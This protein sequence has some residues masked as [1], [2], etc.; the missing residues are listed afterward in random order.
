[1]RLNVFTVADTNYEPF[2]LPYIVS[3]LAHNSDAHVELVLDA[4]LRFTASN[5][6][7]LSIIRDE[8]GERFSFQRNTLS[9]MPANSHRFMLEPKVKSEYVY[10][11]DIDIL[12]LEAITESHLKHMAKTGLP[13]SN[14]IRPNRKALTG[15]HFTRYDAYYPIASIPEGSIQGMDEMLLY[16]I[17]EARGYGLPS[18][19]DVFRPLHGYHLSLNRE[20]KHTLPDRW[21]GI[22]SQRLA[23][24][25]YELWKRPVWQAVVPYFDIRYRILLAVFEATING[26][27]PEVLQDFT[28]SPALQIRSLWQ[29]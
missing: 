19:D 4:P 18:P 15:L 17:V 5:A 10:I 13:F 16:Q 8:F 20:R 2:V 12:V 24:S 9:A 1:M 29:V 23:E 28:I 11:G 14:I 3:V 27:F 25:Y 7:A 21:N 22:G 6:D 26:K